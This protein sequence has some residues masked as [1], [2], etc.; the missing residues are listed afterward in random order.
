MSKLEDNKFNENK[1]KERVLFSSNKIIIL[2]KI[3]S[4]FIS[5]MTKS[6]IQ[7]KT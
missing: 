6:L 3:F 2:K 1:K 5:F 4:I 7:K